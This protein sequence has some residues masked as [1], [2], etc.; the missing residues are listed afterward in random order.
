MPDLMQALR[1]AHRELAD[2]RAH[3]QT[4]AGH[5]ERVR[6]NEAATAAELDRWHKEQQDREAAHGARVITAIAAGQ[7]APA[8]LYD[9]SLTA[10]R[11]RLEAHSR[12]TAQAREQF[13]RAHASAADAVRA[14]EGRV[15]AA[16]DSV[17]QEQALALVKQRRALR[18]QLRDLD[19]QIRGAEEIGV[20]LPPRERTNRIHIPLPLLKQITDAEMNEAQESS[21]G[22]PPDVIDAWKAKRAALIVGTALDNATAAE[23]AA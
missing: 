21:K 19:D 17:L 3:E 5:L 2:A 18:A 1:A 7:N 11:E 15:R 9:L 12:V 4:A 10:D 20:D 6:E 22:P 16:A 13:E 23:A 8:F 14:A